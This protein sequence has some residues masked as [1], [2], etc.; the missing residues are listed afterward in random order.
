[1]RQVEKMPRGD[2]G[3]IAAGPAKR[4]ADRRVQGDHRAA[5]AGQKNIMPCGRKLDRL[6]ETFAVWEERCAD[7]TAVNVETNRACPIFKTA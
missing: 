2:H 5:V 7:V 1:M 3:L 4:I 6:R